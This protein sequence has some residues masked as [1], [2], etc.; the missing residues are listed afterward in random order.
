M[1]EN[2]QGTITRAHGAGG[3]SQAELLRDVIAR[4]F[5][6]AELG[7]LAD[8]AVL[9]FAADRLVMTCDGFVV[10]PRFFPGGSIGKLAAC[11]SIN[12]LAAM[13]GQ[14]LYLT[15]GLII[16]E[17][18]SIDELGQHLQALA[19]TARSVG[20]RVVAG[21]TK[22]VGRGQADG[23]YIS[24]AAVGKLHAG[25]AEGPRP[26]RI[27][28]GDMLLINGGIGEHGMAVLAARAELPLRTTIESDCAAL[29]G[30]VDPL[31]AALGDDVHAMR[32]PTRGGLA[33]A[34]IE[35]AES[36]GVD[37]ELWE[38]KLPISAAVRSVCDIVGFDPLQV[39]NEGKMAAFVASERAEEALALWRAHPLG[40]D[41]ALIGKVTAQSE[42]R[43]WLRTA[44]G[45][46]RRVDMIAGELLPRIC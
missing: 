14:P 43:V 30:L 44:L 27:Q 16:E 23:L 5:D 9:P 31:L 12:D 1:E 34:T 38:D 32:D 37:V 11:G 21:D 7:K 36:S 45:S 25:L 2:L 3:R 41:A 15:V 19:E 10:A 39:A 6:D 29:W 26:D 33:S 24:V 35:L 40:K 46:L 20:A 4:H 8:G 18:L 17:G 42:G 13:G 28:P 22:V